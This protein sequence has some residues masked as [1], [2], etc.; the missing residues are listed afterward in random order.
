MVILK[1]TTIP[2]RINEYANYCLSG[3]LVYDDTN[4]GPISELIKVFSEDR[5]GCL[6]FGIPGSAKTLIFSIL[7]RITNPQDARFFIKRNVLDIV[8]EFNKT[9]YDVF[10]KYKDKHVLFDDLGTEETGKFYADKCN[11]MEVFIQHRYELYQQKGLI[12]HFTTNLNQQE[13]LEKYGLRCVSRLQ[14]LTE[15]ILLGTTQDSQDRRRLKNFI[16]FPPVHHPRIK[17]QEELDWDAQYE[18][19]K[20]IAQQKGV[21]KAPG[22][23]ARTKQQMDL[24]QE[25][26]AAVIAAGLKYQKDKIARMILL[27]PEKDNMGFITELTAAHNSIGVVNQSPPIKEIVAK[28]IPICRDLWQKQLLEE[29]NKKD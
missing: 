6:V 10:Q 20:A 9:G 18:R 3:G 4:R 8:Q 26:G 27:I 7:Q 5:Y 17:T 25:A 19:S 2:E 21:Q 13:I 12:T 29:L 23:G 15:T 16:G 14:E 22:L 1:S 28:Y 11:V 24:Y